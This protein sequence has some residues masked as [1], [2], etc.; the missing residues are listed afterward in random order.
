MLR[1]IG[2]FFLGL[3]MFACFVPAYSMLVVFPVTFVFG[4]HDS[5]FAIELATTYLLSAATAVWIVA[6]LWT[7]KGTARTPTSQDQAPKNDP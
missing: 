7:P 5:L 1:E 6:K 3:M 4:A 2:L